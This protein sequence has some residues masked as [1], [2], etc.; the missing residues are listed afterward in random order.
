MPYEA[1]AIVGPTASGK[2]ELAARVGRKLREKGLDV[3]FISCDSR[4]VYK[5]FDIGTAKPTKYM[6]EFKWHFIS[7]KEVYE[8][9][10]AKDFE[11]KGRELIKKIKSEGKIPIVVGGTWL[12]LRALEL[13]LFPEKEDRNLRRELEEKLNKEGKERLFAMLKELDP[14]ASCK[15]HPNDTYRVIRAIEVKLKSG[16]S[17]TEAGFGELF[18]IAKFGVYRSKEVLKERIKQRVMKQIEQ[19]LIDEI[20]TAL[21]K[22]GEVTPMLKSIACYEP[23]LYVTG[24]I[25]LDE[26]IRLMIN[27]N[28]RYARYQI[29]VFSREGTMWFSSDE[30]LVD[31][32]TRFVL[33]R[34]IF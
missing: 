6:N 16:K 14:A 24:R 30:N 34:N 22:Y 2:S 11:V 5:D 31:F 9:F 32:I 20:K 29:K 19:G 25:S 23:Y 3:E 33:E 12:Y 15:I 8:S 26:M 1:L 28:F 21:E 7:I 18:P 13:G 4:K 10:S 27:H 17:I